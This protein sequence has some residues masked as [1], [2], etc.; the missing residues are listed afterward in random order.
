MPIN[1][2]LLNLQSYVP[3]PIVQALAHGR[4]PTQAPEQ[5][6][7]HAAVLLVDIS[8]FTAL[9]EQLAMRGPVGAEELSRI[10][11]T[12]FDHI[13]QL[14][15]A[16]GGQIVQFVGDALIVVWP[17]ADA[18]TVQ[19]ALATA[20]QRALQCALLLE[21]QLN[22][23]TAQPQM[24]L[25]LK[26]IAGAGEVMATG[27]GGLRDRWQ[28][29][30]T[31]PAVAQI[32][33]A[34]PLA[35]PG[36]VI[37]SPEAWRLVQDRGQGEMLPGGA[38]RLQSMA[39]IRPSP[40]PTYQL[41]PETEPHL[42]RYV[43]HFVQDHLPASRHG[44]LAELRRLTIL[45][46]NV[47]LEYNAPPALALLQRAVTAVQEILY[48]YEGHWTRIVVDEK[49]TTLLMVLGLPPYTHEN[50]PLR[51]IQVAL[52][53]NPVF[54]SLGINGTIGIT[55][56]RVFCGEQGNTRRR[57][58]T[59]LGN[60]VN[61]AARLMN[62]ARPFSQGAGIT[63]LC[64][65]AT[66]Q[67]T[68]DAVNYDIMPPLTLKGLADPIAV[69]WPLAPAP[70]KLAA[71]QEI[72]AAWPL[73]GREAE[74][75]FLRQ[76]IDTLMA[77]GQTRVVVIEGEAGI[78]KSH[79]AEVLLHYAS[80]QNIPGLFAHA[81]AIE[82]VTP[83]H[84]WRSLMSQLWG[85]GGSEG[86]H[87]DST[88]V[89]QQLQARFAHLPEL[90]PLLPLLNPVLG[91][92]MPDTDITAQMNLENRADNTRHLLVTL[93]QQTVNLALPH[94]LLLED[95]QWMDSAS[96]RVLAGVRERLRPW[97]ILL[98]A[99]TYVL[100]STPL[101]D[102]ANRLLSAPDTQHLKL[103]AL[104]DD[105]SLELVQQR[106]G[107]ES[108]P[109]T[110][111]TLIRQ[112]AE[113]HP[114][115]SEEIAYALRDE[116]Y[117]VIKDGHCRLTAKATHLPQINFP[118]TI[119]GVITS[120]IARLS[121]EQQLTVKVASVIG[122]IFALTVLSGVYPIP[123]ERERVSAYVTDLDKLNI[124]PYYSADPEISYVFR[125]I[126]SREVAYNLMLYAQRQQIHQA[127][128]NWYKIAYAHD[129]DRIYPLLAY[130]WYEAARIG[131]VDEEV[132]RQAITY[133]D[134]AG[135][136]AL[137]NGAMREAAGFFGNLLD[138][139]THIPVNSPLHQEV[140]AL[141]HGRWQRQMGQALLQSGQAAAARPHLEQALHWLGFPVRRATARL[142]VG[143]VGQ[144][145]RQALHRLFPGRFLQRQGQDSERLVE[146]AYVYDYLG[147][148]HFIANETLSAM[149]YSIC[150]LNVA[151]AA[152]PSPQLGAYASICMTM[153]LLT[154][155]SLAERY[156][157]LAIAAAE[158][159]DDLAAHGLT[160]LRVNAHY[161]SYCRWPMARKLSS[162]IDAICEQLSDWQLWATN[163]GLM[164]AVAK[165]TGNFQEALAVARQGYVYSQR[166]GNR[167]HDTWTLKNLGEIN[168]TLGHMEEGLQAERQILD[169]LTEYPNESVE[170]S[171]YGTLALA[172]W[173]LGEP[174]LA[175]D[176][177]VKGLAMISHTIPVAF[178]TLP[179]YSG[180]A[181]VLLQLQATGFKT[182]ELAA[183]TRQS[184]RSLQSFARSFPV[185]RPYLY[186][187]QGLA[188]WQAGKEAKA[189]KTWQKG[190]AVAEGQGMP[191]EKGLLLAAYGRVLPASHPH[192]EQ[193]LAEA[194]HIFERLGCQYDLAQV[195]AVR[196]Q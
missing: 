8:G 92:A 7:W 26:T 144:Y 143:T 158:G 153:S 42:R 15:T 182:P 59:F 91:V 44:W 39:D 43:F 24:K 159:M 161:I 1:N 6:T 109:T 139:F 19:M 81:D 49:G 190:V 67:A 183:Q 46:L 14:V 162:E 130:H 169:I 22:G 157:A 124:T 58:Y 140:P 146:A 149:Y 23:Y 52:A 89:L 176:A 196:D 76:Q 133:L 30:M 119:E 64:D 129:L 180:V 57:E 123:E 115:F 160:K 83:Y 132:Y 18:P 66:Y 28:Y 88:A 98:T 10:L 107:V 34:G 38:V 116:G 168:V 75:A 12:L 36:T 9:T 186:L 105:H 166:S 127:V 170:L 85:I 13:I 147:E 54:T 25:Y 11:N 45:F 131:Q 172:Y 178:F 187:C 90:L 113:G 96:W 79:L 189:L 188:A 193:L 99:R 100:Q 135:E 61:L 138:L 71:R 118:T 17:A 78:G 74:L 103:D 141:Q 21:K 145:G 41:P 134:K 5:E 142:V 51:G 35:A 117:I 37:V 60:V 69:Y 95:V 56:G 102:E 40:T 93:L 4:V 84:A 80:Q 150:R 68:H 185:A 104:G 137:R 62:A 111:S 110:V 27:V 126:L 112:T 155:D 73:L 136:Q 128:A 32:S 120:R 171:T 165:Y 175:Y 121:S 48:R 87:V 86:E 148:V 65:Q 3:E 177:A 179:G 195:T 63:A 53:L 77:T 191:Y 106:L 194:T 82:K 29:L 94:V 167:V 108:L 47:N 122:R 2:P 163:A 101:P 181:E 97:L 125:H 55:T 174:A 114:F 31:G 184:V 16:Q 72:S 20:T 192:R 164:A 154:F 33:R 156:G 152:R 50:D 70:T 151:E 173:R